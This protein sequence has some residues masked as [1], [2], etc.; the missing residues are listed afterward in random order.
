MQG[1]CE[2]KYCRCSVLIRIM[3][4]AQSKDEQRHTVQDRASKLVCTTQVPEDLPSA[5]P[6]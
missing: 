4:I 6:Q 1:S 5:A 2:R 3:L